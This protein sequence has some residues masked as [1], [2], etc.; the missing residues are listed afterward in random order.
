[1]NKERNMIIAKNIRRF[2][3]DSNM[4]QKKLAELINIKPST[5]SDYLNLRSNP[6]HGVIQRIADVFGVGKS[7]I[8]TTY[9]DNND[10]T[11]IYNKLTPPRQ[12]NVL[13]YA[14]DQLEEQNSKGDN[15]VD[16]N[17]Y[18]QDK[19]EV[20]V[21]GCVSAGVGERLHEETLFT[22]MVKAPVPPHDLA[23]KVNGDSMEPMFKD[24]EIIFVE[25]THN[26]K[27]GQIGIFIIEEEAY[28]KKVIV[29]DDR[30]TLISLNKN[31]KDLHFY[32]N[33]SVKLV[34]KVIL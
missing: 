26:I 34:G 29:E 5:L 23:L 30:L 28:L 22:E 24:G 15:V 1:M 13:N 33:Q 11:S 20:N 32:E 4:S 19:I 7:D 3:K 10:I 2:L 16:I 25:K 8:D 12:Q 18:K 6:S 31:Y 9:K 27:N 14:H 17:S 21:N